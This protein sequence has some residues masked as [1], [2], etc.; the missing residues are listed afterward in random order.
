M[1]L[2]LIKVLDSI[3]NM[4]IITGTHVL[5]DLLSKLFVNPSFDIVACCESDN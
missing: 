2:I 3:G 5:I 4:R 1:G